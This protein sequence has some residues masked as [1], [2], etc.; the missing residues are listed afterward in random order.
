M[1]TPYRIDIPQADLDDLRARLTQT[2][3]PSEIPGQEWTR[4]V[5]V[6]YLRE[7]VDYWLNSY[8]WRKHEAELNEFPQFT[9]EIDGQTIHF[10]HIRSANP[11][12][13]PLILSHGWPGSIVE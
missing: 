5:P 9:I 4:G 10:I 1:I 11:D 7:L 3:W 8:D 12:A 13:V 2:R 6:A